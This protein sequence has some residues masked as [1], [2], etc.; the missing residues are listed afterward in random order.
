MQQVECTLKE[1]AGR[2]YRRLLLLRRIFEQQPDSDDGEWSGPLPRSSAALCEAITE[3]IDELTDHAGTLMTAPFP[4]S[5]WRSGDGPDDERWR[6]LT[7]I[8]RRELLTLISRYEDLIEWSEA[9]ACGGSR[10]TILAPDRT[11]GP[12]Q[13]L[14]SDADDYLKAQ[15]VQL[16]R[17]R[18]D[19]LFLDRRRIA[20]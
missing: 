3:V 10:S 1:R 7:E 6:A 16:G 18:H 8:E 9:R 5:E 20:E 17:F 12:G 13:G 15:R 19:L 14:L 4:I 11:L 2:M